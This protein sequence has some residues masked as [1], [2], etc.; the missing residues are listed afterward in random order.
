M[1]IARLSFVFAVLLTLFVMD[2]G[3]MPIP[4]QTLR[5]LT[6]KSEL[7]VSARV[8][9]IAFI[10]D[11]DGFKTGIARLNILSVVKGA[12]GSQSIDVYYSANMVCPE[13]PRYKEGDTVLAFLSR[14]EHYQGYL[15]VGLSYGAKSMTNR[16]IEA[17]SARIRELIEIERQADP[18]ARQQQ[19]VEWLVRCV[20]EPITMWEGAYDLLNSRELKK[21][22]EREIERRKAQGAQ[23]IAADVDKMGSRKIE[24]DFTVLLS[25]DQKRRL[26]AALYRTS[27]L[28]GGVMELIQLVE[29]LGDE[30]LVPFMWSYLK[31]FKKDHPWETNALMHK[32]ANS[33]MNQEALELIKKFDCGDYANTE[34]RARIEQERETILQHFIQAIERSGAPRI[35]EINN[36]P[37]TPADSSPHQQSAKGGTGLRAMLFAFAILLVPVAAFRWR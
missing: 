14:S 20:E 30:N 3:A 17:Y 18:L 2:V 15:T 36:E 5:M 19:L 16:K 21:M 31:A 35:V 32:L 25:E 28:S 13:P 29:L 6:N 8:E 7:I 27:S 1:R 24:I 33:L 34:E 10:E 11:T 9:Q 4:P 23:A 22:Y 37:E 12:D 26:T